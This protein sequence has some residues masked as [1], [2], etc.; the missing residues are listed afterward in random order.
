MVWDI[1][2]SRR[3]T[4]LQANMLKCLIRD[5]LRMRNSLSLPERAVIYVFLMFIFERQTECEW[6]RGGAG[7][8]GDT[9]SEAGSSL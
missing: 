9:E 8:E 6:R 4:V 3:K 2:P 1:L 5:N 7:R